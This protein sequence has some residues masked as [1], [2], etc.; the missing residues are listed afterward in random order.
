MTIKIGVVM[1]PL[2]SIHFEKDSTLAML[3]EAQA[4]GWK[5]F[6][7][8]LNHL[9]LSENTVYGDARRLNLLPNTNPWFK[10]KDKER[11]SLAEFDVILM[12]KDPPVNDDYLYTTY[13]LE[14][15]EKSGVFVVNKPNALRDANEKIFTSYFP[16]C[17]PPTL[18]T[19]SIAKL[20]DFFIQYSDIVCKP[21]HSMGGKSVFHLQNNDKNANAIFDLLTEG[22]NHF[23]MAQKFIPEIA[24]GDKRILLINGEPI[25]YV[26]SRIPQED[27]WRGNLAVGAKGIAQA[28]SKRDQ[29][30]CEQI[31]PTLRERGL[32]FVGIDVIGE[33][34]TEINV[35]SPTGICEITAQTGFNAAAILLDLIENHLT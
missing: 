16:Q 20:K 34:L 12:R 32:F 14:H 6:Y 26:L 30:I 35:T 5:I 28:L 25:P 1:D 9:F 2:G 33:Y 31:G 29:W 21:L 19:S 3:L 10:L 24:Q 13:L 17:C 11:L 27:D 15:A 4:R 8:E 23:I 18:V 22:G 7:F